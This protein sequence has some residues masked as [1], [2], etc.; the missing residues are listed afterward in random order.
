MTQLQ[1]KTVDVNLCPKVAN[2]MWKEISGEILIFSHS[3]RKLFKTNSTGKF[4]FELS[5]GKC[6]VNHIIDSVAKE[7]DAEIK[8][9][10]E[11]VI[12]FFADLNTLGF[13]IWIKL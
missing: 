4:I 13:I 7:Y 3:S 2:A 5:N 1:C 10:K 11:D 12:D 8:E 6:T 9:I